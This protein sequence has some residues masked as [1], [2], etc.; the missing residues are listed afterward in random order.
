MY[1]LKETYYAI[2]QQV[3][4]VFEFQK[5][6]F[7]SVFITV[8]E[9]LSE[10][11]I[12]LQKIMYRLIS[13]FVCVWEHQKKQHPKSQEKCCFHN[14]SPLSL[15]AV[16]SMTHPFDFF[17]L[18]MHRPQHCLTFRHDIHSR[19]GRSQDNPAE[20]WSQTSGRS[21]TS[22]QAQGGGVEVGG[23]RMF[24][25]GETRCGISEPASMF[26]VKGQPEYCVRES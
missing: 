23:W 21:D 26:V 2:S 3:N 20:M 1:N 24:G 6:C 8:G 18:N 15:S 4:I 17:A 11:H 10:M 25:S 19:G 13:K 14:T 12:S 22:R 16:V 9:V 7:W 5:T